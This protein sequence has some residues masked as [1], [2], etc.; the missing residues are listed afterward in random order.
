MNLAVAETHFPARLDRSNSEK[1][2]EPRCGGPAFPSKARDE[3]R[4]LKAVT[5]FFAI[6]R[7]GDLF[8]CARSSKCHW[9]IVIFPF[10]IIIQ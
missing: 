8:A 2:T 10:Y 3:P 6:A 1:P 5:T 4:L 7:H 9:P